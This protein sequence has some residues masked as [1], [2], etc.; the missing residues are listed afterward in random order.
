MITELES[1]KT[2]TGVGS[3]Q[4]EDSFEAGVEIARNAISANS[5]LTDTLFFLFAT[6]EHN[7]IG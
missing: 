4:K 7:P 3:S 2:I 6:A 1:L 5:M